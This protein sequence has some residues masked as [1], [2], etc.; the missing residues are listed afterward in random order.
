MQI[1]KVKIAPY[2]PSANDQVE[3]YNHTIMDARA[4]AVRCYIGKSQNQWDKHPSQIAGAIRSTVNQS[5]GFTANKLMLG[6]K[7]SIYQLIL[8]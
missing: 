3:P 7:K 6:V 5:T 1:H 8:C 2:R 4:C